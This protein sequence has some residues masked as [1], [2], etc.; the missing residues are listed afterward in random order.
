MNIVGKFVDVSG[1]STHVAALQFTGWKPSFIVVH[2]TS[3][4]SLANYAE[5]RAN[6]E[7]HGHWI[8]EQWLQNLRG[9]YS[10]L[11]WNSGP[12]AFVTP[13]G[14]GLFTPF[15][16]HGTHSPAWN[17]IT[18]GV[19]TVG[20]FETESFDN[21]V[22]DNLIS[23]L[24]ILH[25]RIGLNPADYKFGVRG[26]HFHKEDPVTTHKTCPGKHMVKTDLV[27]AVVAYMQNDH[28]GDHAEVPLAIHT[29]PAKFVPNDPIAVR[30]I[31]IVATCFGGSGDA[32]ASAYGG[33]V[34]P[35]KPGVALPARLSPPLAKVRVFYN[36]HNVAVPPSVLC[37]IVDVGPHHTDDPYW[38]TGARPRA[39]GESG[40]KAGIDMTPGVFAALGVAKNDPAWGLTKV[41]WEFV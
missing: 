28:P 36:P 26:I 3:S 38:K 9:Y 6:P 17:S 2:N 19:E 1:F 11:G 14:I 34:D 20:E 15:T 35:D 33:Q 31:E 22:R 13:D 30:Q 5:W 18:W 37:D 24:G 32:N 16:Q 23:V 29:E 7:K 27:A 39:E 8:P 4:P 10:D 40:N 25:A 21:G 12:H 41:D